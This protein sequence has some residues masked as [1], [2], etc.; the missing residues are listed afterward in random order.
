[1]QGSAPAHMITPSSSP[2]QNSV[3]NPTGSHPWTSRTARFTRPPAAMKPTANS[4]RTSIL[5]S[6]SFVRS[7]GMAARFFRVSWSSS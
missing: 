6:T 3:Q 7:T 5:E 1:M 2:T 4:S